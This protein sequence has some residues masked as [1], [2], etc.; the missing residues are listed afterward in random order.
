MSAWILALWGRV[1]VRARLILAAI[2]SAIAGAA[3]IFLWGRR[4]GRQEGAGDARLVAARVDAQR[5]RDM[6]A[7]GDDAGVQAELARATERARKV[8]GRK[9]R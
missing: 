7:A 6:G 3:A 5:I 4:R 1:P 8:T 9:Q 2:G